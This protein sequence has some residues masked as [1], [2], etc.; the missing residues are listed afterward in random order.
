MGGAWLPATT[1]NTLEPIVWRHRFPPDITA[2]LVSD[3]D[4]V[5]T[6]ANLD[7][8]L[9]GTVVHQDMLVQHHNCNHCTIHILND[10][11]LAVAW[12]KKGSA[13]A[14]GP[15]AYLSG[16]SAL[17]Q[18]HHHFL[19]LTDHMPGV[20]NAIADD[21]SRLWHLTDSQLLTHLNSLYPQ[22]QPWRIVH[23]QPEMLASV[24]TALCASRPQL[25]LCLN[26]PKTKTVIDASGS[27]SAAPFAC[28]RTCHQSRTSCLFSRCLPCDCNRENLHPAKN[29]SNLSK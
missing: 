25:Q 16:V 3:C 20:T 17:H 6:I 28:P 14:T 24:T 7:L 10:N 2:D 5:G 21:L 1:H 26:D 11:V 23:L 13:T 19:V 22:K 27:T 9:A 12:R 4:P 29:L 15:A 8:E 18:R